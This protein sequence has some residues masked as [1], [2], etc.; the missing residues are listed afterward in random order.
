MKKKL[1]FGIEIE[2]FDYTFIYPKLIWARFNY[3]EYK[4]KPVLQIKLADSFRISFESKILITVGR[5]YNP[6]IILREDK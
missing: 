6:G 3:E 5:A 2:T 1:L 4:Y